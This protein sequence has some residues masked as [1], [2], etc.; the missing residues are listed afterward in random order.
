MAHTH[1]HSTV[2]FDKSGKQV[3]HLAVPYS[4]NLAGWA[5]LQRKALQGVGECLFVDVGEFVP[6]LFSEM[7]VVCKLVS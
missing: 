2:D 1:I 7:F 4:Y 6:Y 5:N 3:G